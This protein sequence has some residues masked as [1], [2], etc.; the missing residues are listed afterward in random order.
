[1]VKIAKYAL[2]GVVLGVAVHVAVLAFWTAAALLL[3]FAATAMS[4]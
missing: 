1:M 4:G 2:L 3:S